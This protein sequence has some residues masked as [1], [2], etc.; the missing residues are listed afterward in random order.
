MIKEHADELDFKSL[1]IE[2]FLEFVVGDCRAFNLVDMP[3]FRN[4]IV[5]VVQML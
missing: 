1:L 3:N 2:Y 5:N 4:L